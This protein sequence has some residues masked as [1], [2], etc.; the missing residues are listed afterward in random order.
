MVEEV[1]DLE[2]LCLELDTFSKLVI[3]WSLFLFFNQQFITRGAKAVRGSYFIT[4]YIRTKQ[5]EKNHFTK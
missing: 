2:K 1:V 3:N 4:T 5:K